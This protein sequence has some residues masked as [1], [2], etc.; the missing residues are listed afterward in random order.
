MHFREERSRFHRKLG[1]L[2]KMTIHCIVHLLY[3]TCVEIVFC[4]AAA[5]AAMFRGRLN[6]SYGNY[7]DDLSN[8]S[9]TRHAEL[10]AKVQPLLDEA[11]A[12]RNGTIF[13]EVAAF[14]KGS[15]ILW[16]VF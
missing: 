5:L 6:D 14:T 10:A 1:T 2:V 13:S 12:G 3:L 9:S 7:S 15:I 16:L 4:S 8:D 11:F